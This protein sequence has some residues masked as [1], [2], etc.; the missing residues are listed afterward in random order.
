[1]NISGYDDLLSA[2]AQQAEPQRLLFVFAS[3]ELPVNCTEAQKAQYEAKRGGAL[4]PVMCADKLPAELGSF[5]SLVEESRQMGMNWDI[6]FV[7]SM[8]GRAG[9]APSSKEADPFLE[10]MVESI[11]SGSFSKF[12][13]FDRN[14]ALVQFSKA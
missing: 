7:S 6:V 3:A 2:A 14:A 4:A 5:D 11:K 8:S 9:V 13:A 1:M 10:R 12:L